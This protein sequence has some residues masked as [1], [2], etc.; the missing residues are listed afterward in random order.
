MSLYKL[1]LLILIPTITVTPPDTVQCSIWPE[2]DEGRDRGEVPIAALARKIAGSE[3]Y[4]HP[5]NVCIALNG[6]QGV[7]VLT[8][9]ILCG[10]K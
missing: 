5:V 9:Q 2:E 7:C 10:L 8:C 4:Y 1:Q 3:I 6:L